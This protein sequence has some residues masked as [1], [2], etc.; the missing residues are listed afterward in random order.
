MNGI[1]GVA[2][3]SNL[4]AMM[5]S[6]AIAGS[7]NQVGPAATSCHMSPADFFNRLRNLIRKPSQEPTPT[8]QGPEKP[9]PKSP[10][11][12]SATVEGRSTTY[13]ESWT[14]S[15]DASGRQRTFDEMYYGTWDGERLVELLAQY[16]SEMHDLQKALQQ[17]ANESPR[18]R[19]FCDALEAVQY[20]LVQVSIPLRAQI[21][22]PRY[23]SHLTEKAEARQLLSRTDYEGILA[24][25]R[26]GC[27]R[28]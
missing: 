24:E 11:R 5:A 3:L 17:E 15:G 9:D 20:N 19:R 14:W 1:L 25:A 7:S 12:Q 23:I 10:Y 2:A 4:W 26:R 16:E 21:W 28:V 13:R 27:Q 18:R 6:G 8:P 22:I